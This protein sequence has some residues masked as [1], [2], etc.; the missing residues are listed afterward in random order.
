MTSDLVAD[1]GWNLA[2]FTV[3]LSPYQKYDVNVKYLQPW[4]QALDKET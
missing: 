4:N 1:K 3:V 2:P